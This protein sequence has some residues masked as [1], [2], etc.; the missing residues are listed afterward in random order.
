M[1]LKDIEEYK[2][3]HDFHDVK[4]SNIKKVS[5][6]VIIT[7]V[8]MIAEIICG[9]I[10]NSMA[11]LSDGWHMT[12]HASAL[13]ITLFTYFIARKHKD[14]ARYAFGTWKVEIL[15]AYTSAILLG[16]V[17]IYVIYSSLVR[18]FNPADIHYNEALVVAVIGL[19][20]NILC[21]VILSYDEHEHANIHHHDGH[22]H[23]H[24]HDLNIKSAYLHV[25]ADALTSVFAI[26]ALLCAKLLQLNMLDPLMGI[27]SSALIF[28]W[29]Y[30][31]LKETSTILLDKDKNEE[32]INEIKTIIESNGDTKI[33]DLHL[34]KVGQNKYGCIISLVAACHK[35]LDE[36]KESLKDVHELAHVSIEMIEC[37]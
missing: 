33:S 36:Y 21:A 17:G 37:K 10:F 35:S 23:H 2:H 25:L 14:D 31:L 16:I 1:H 19:A 13:G 6:V 24:D 28:K 15:G 3:L 9:W 12:T 5:F 8:T 18:I 34:W 4:E 32:L 22:E 20:V 11:L 27:V 30:G 29:S 7:M 26:A